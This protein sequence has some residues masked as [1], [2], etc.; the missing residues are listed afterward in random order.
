MSLQD[1]LKTLKDT[2]AQ[3][4]K[5]IAATENTINAS[6]DSL[7]KNANSNELKSIQKQVMQVKSL[8]VK[9]KSGKNVDVEIS[10]IANNIN[11]GRR[12]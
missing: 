5:M 3:T 7:M 6:M 11:N 1:S 2:V 12:D 9:A 10:N 8:L 4:N